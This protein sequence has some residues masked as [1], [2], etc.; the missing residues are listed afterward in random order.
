M[1]QPLPACA[2]PGAGEFI[3][4]VETP[5]T[6]SEKK[7]KQVLPPTVSIPVCDYL[8]N[9]VSRMGGFRNF[10]D[11]NAWAEYITQASGLKAFVAQAPTSQASVPPS[12][13]PLNTLPTAAPATPRFTAKA[14]GQGYAVIVNFFN[15]PA[16]AQQLNLAQSRIPGLVSYNGRP[17]L[18]ALHTADSTTALASLQKLTEQGFQVFVVDARQTLLLTEAVKVR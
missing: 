9:R 4:L 15:N 7:L 1:A 12:P 6:A 3:L 8:S 2:P 11:A 17:Y 5:T 14:V 18:L 10:T 16:V 13:P